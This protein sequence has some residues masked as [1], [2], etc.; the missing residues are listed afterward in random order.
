M[1]TACTSAGEVTTTTE[2]PEPT[3]ADSTAPTTTEAIESANAG[4]PA[5]TDEALETGSRDDM[6]HRPYHPCTLAPLSAVPEPDPAIERGRTRIISSGA[7]PV[8]S[9]HLQVAGFAPGAPSLNPSACPLIR[10]SSTM[11]PVRWSPVTSPQV[12]P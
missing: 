5:T 3:E 1:L 7:R 8:L 9:P 11:A 12:Q 2:I 6:F 4:S 10:H